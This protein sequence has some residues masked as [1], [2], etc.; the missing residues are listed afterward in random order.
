MSTWP[1][2]PGLRNERCKVFWVGPEPWLL[3]TRAGPR[4]SLPEAS[5]FQGL[6]QKDKHKLTCVSY[7]II[8]ST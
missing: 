8:I 3:N 2:G 5:T 1:L 6:L 4:T 7:R